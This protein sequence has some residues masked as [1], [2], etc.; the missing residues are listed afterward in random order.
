[1]IPGSQFRSQPAPPVR[2]H[3]A[4]RAR[5]PAPS[6]MPCAFSIGACMISLHKVR[7]ASAVGCAGGWYHAASE[8]RTGHRA[9]HRR[10]KNCQ[11]AV[12]LCRYFILAQS[13]L[14]G[15]QKL[16]YVRPMKRHLVYTTEGLTSEKNT[17]QVLHVVN[18]RGRDGKLCARWTS[19]RLLPATQAHVCP[20]L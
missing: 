13:T 1:M 6:F 5:T 9:G 14:Q 3:E 4:S 2:F 18:E 16:T 10:R 7:A 8:Y 12:Y 17:Y 19:S 20:G 11:Y 15:L